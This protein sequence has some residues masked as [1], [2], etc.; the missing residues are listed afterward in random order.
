[1]RVLVRISPLIA[2]MG[3][4]AA[5]AWKERRGI[6]EWVAA[7]EQDY[8]TE[9]ELGQDYGRQGADLTPIWR[10][11]LEPGYGGAAIDGDEVF[12]LDRE[13]GVA[14]TLRVFD[15]WS[16]QERWRFR[17]DAPGRLEFPGSRTTP[18]VTATHVYLLS[19]FGH[20]H[21]IDRAS[22]EVTW[23]CRLEDFGGALPDFG[24]AA[25]P[26]VLGEVVVLPALGAAVGLVALDVVSG[27][28]V[29]RTSGLGSSHSTP[30]VLDLLGERHVVFLSAEEQGRGQDSAVPMTV[31][32][33]APD[34]GKLLWR[35]TP[36]G[37]SVPIPPPVAVDDHRIFV[38]GGYGGGSTLLSIEKS[39]DYVVREVFHVDKGAQLHPPVVLD[40]YLYLLANENRNDSR[41]R[42]HL[43]G[44]VCYDLEGNEL[45][46]TGDA[47]YMG[48]G[49]MLRVGRHLLI[50]D[51]LSGFLRFVRAAPD[52]YH[53]VFTANAF[54]SP[55]KDRRR[56]W[57]PMA[58]AKGTVVVRG[59]RELACILLGGKPPGN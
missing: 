21:C 28:E 15:L 6:L 36:S 7:P 4:A 52:G 3:L 18:A 40:G 55:P 57:A 27:R 54:E 10:V 59:E 58:R 41:V 44:L 38:T 46:S 2:L 19:S 8:T 50:Q 39:G 56:M 43:G 29:W 11:A 32:A 48:R 24:W 33:F 17:Y 51:G 5:W 37:S 53:Q 13:V 26:L 9:F 35:A 45:W 14:D 47:P 25:T 12:V 34:S 30:V 49:H 42:R 1:M 23:S 31:S 22:H 16:G 20:V